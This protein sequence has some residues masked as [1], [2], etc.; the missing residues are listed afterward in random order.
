MNYCCRDSLNSQGL[1]LFARPWFYLLVAR[2][3]CA[4]LF[5]RANTNSLPM[6]DV[7][8][9]DL[10]GGVSQPSVCSEVKP[11]FLSAFKSNWIPAVFVWG[12]ALALVLVYYIVP[13]A[14]PV[15]SFISNLKSEWG[16][17][18]SGLPSLPTWNSS[19]IFSD[20]ALATVIFATVL[21]FPLIMWRKKWACREGLAHFL[22]S[23]AYWTWKGALFVCLCFGLV[24][25][26]H[27]R[28]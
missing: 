2:I 21:P 9:V 7:R 16:F 23:V 22:F 12:L 26:L 4:S 15:Y 1:F 13:E 10:E 24:I 20:L 3:L 19:C 5:S 8:A 25:Q 28:H 6:A 18:F 17:G 11:I 14:E 27:S